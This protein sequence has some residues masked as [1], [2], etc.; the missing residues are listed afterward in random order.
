MLSLLPA[1]SGDDLISFWDP[2]TQCRCLAP[3]FSWML[4][5]I[6]GHDLSTHRAAQ[7]TASGGAHRALYSQPEATSLLL[8]PRAPDPTPWAGFPA[9]EPLLPLPAHSNLVFASCASLASRLQTNYLSLWAS[10]VCTCKLWVRIII[11]YYC[12]V[13]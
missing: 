8:P 2:V 1:C 11:F 12:P 10:R 7:E 9:P 6:L 4:L 3:E 5:R 13:H